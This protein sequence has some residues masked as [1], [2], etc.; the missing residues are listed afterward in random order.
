MEKERVD[1][2]SNS[3]GQLSPFSFCLYFYSTENLMLTILK[4]D[5]DYHDNELE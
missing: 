3:F 2:K 1:T 4:S 5:S